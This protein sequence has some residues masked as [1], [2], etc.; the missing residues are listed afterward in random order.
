MSMTSQ[1]PHSDFGKSAKS[2]PE[3]EQGTE[4][5][6]KPSSISTRWA[7]L[8]DA[9]NAV[10]AMAGMMPTPTNSQIRNFPAVIR[11]AGGWRLE[12]AE[13]G[14]QD[15][16]AFMEPGLAA[17]LAVNARGQDASAPALALWHEFH[18]ARAALLA[19]PPETG[20]MGPRRSA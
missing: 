3:A 18:A 20:T 2:V 16:A 6:A 5:R 12:M 17:L 14:I 8:G 9:G 7:A 11:D 4:F 1:P 13:N 15:L 19:L 10:A